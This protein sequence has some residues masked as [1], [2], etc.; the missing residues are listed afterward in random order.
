MARFFYIM[1]AAPEISFI[2]T[3]TTG[4][5]FLWHGM[6][7][8]TVYLCDIFNL[9]N[10]LNLSLQI[11]E[12]WGEWQLWRRMMTV[13]K[14]AYKV[15]AFKAKLELWG[16]WVNIG[17]FITF[18]SNIRRSFGRDWTRA[19]CLPAGTISAFKRL[20]ALLPNHKNYCPDLG[21]K[22]SMTHLWIHQVSGLC[23]Y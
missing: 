4:N 2:K 16:W 19:F 5:T 14:L 11:E 22:E 12:W 6:G 1:R 8:K 20:W 9:L 10:E 18:L 21:R 23:P 15:L 17:I 7:C 13:F 3:V